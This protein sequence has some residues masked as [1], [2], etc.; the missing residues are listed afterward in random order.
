M[1]EQSIAERFDI[2]E[3]LGSPSRKFICDELLTPNAE[4]DAAV[5]PFNFPA[6]SST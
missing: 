5:I 1:A 3:I 4:T 2:G 6:R